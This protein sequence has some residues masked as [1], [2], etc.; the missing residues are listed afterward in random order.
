M[1]DKKNQLRAPKTGFKKWNGNRQVISVDFSRIEKDER[2]RQLFWIKGE[3]G[4]L[5]KFTLMDYA[6]RQYYPRIY[7]VYTIN[8][9]GEITEEGPFFSTGEPTQED[10]FKPND[11]SR[12]IIT[13]ARKDLNNKNS[14]K[15]FE[16]L[17]PSQCMQMLH[18]RFERVIAENGSNW[19]RVASAPKT[20]LLEQAL[21]NSTGHIVHRTNEQIHLDAT[22][23]ERGICAIAPEKARKGDYIRAATNEEV[24]SAKKELMQLF[25][26]NHTYGSPILSEPAPSTPVA[27]STVQTPEIT[28][29]EC[30][31]AAEAINRDRARLP[32]RREPGPASRFLHGHKYKYDP[33]GNR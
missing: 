27:E 31:V 2:Q 12:A 19:Y 9:N 22:D 1:E 5:S 15:E 30:A 32:S 6:G 20:T 28:A 7:I 21:F 33:H 10:I 25:A 13:I 18:M 17:T 3:K 11:N 8:A 24:A 16:G 26:E 29:E 23:T 14:W 4:L